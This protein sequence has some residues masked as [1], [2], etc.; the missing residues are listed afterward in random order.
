[1]ESL[2]ERDMMEVSFGY[3]D[4][5]DVSSMPEEVLSSTIPLKRQLD[6]D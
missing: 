5:C 1:M 6:A 2:L 3:C 4:G